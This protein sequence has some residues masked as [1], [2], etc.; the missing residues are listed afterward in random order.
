[1]FSCSCRRS[2]NCKAR[3]YI[4]Q[5]DDN[6][7][8]VLTKEH[9]HPP[10]YMLEKKAEI[11]KVLKQ[12]SMSLP[13]QPCQIYSSVVSVY[14]ET[15]ELFPFNSVEASIKSVQSTQSPP[16]ENEKN[17]CEF[18]KE[19]KKVCQSG[20][21]HL[22]LR[23]VY[24]HVAECHPEGAVLKPFDTIRSSMSRWRKDAGI[25]EGV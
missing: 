16:D 22:Q 20:T 21:F 13:G 12:F 19:L 10:D 18:L 14:P 1:F 24:Q 15:E 6:N 7:Q 25:N 23:D 2:S 3:A 4:L 11:W 5:G 9:S 17:I 8:L